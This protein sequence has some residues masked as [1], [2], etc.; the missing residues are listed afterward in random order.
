MESKEQHLINAGFQKVNYIEFQPSG[1]ILHSK[2]YSDGFLLADPYD[3]DGYKRISFD[4]SQLKALL[5]SLDIHLG[6]I[7]GELILCQ[8]PPEVDR[9]QDIQ[10]VYAKVGN[11]QLLEFCL[12]EIFDDQ[13]EAWI[14]YTYKGDFTICWGEL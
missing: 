9:P 1:L 7:P 11:N 6:R 12:H 2:E 8:L 3:D 5:K 10:V 4:T 14:M 13:S